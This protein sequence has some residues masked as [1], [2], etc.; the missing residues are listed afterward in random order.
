MRKPLT[1][2]DFTPDDSM[3]FNHDLNRILV[4][5]FLGVEFSQK[6]ETSNPQLQDNLRLI[7]GKLKKGEIY[8]D[9]YSTQNIFLVEI[10]L[11]HIK[12]KQ[13]EIAV[14]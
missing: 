3:M 1:T 7:S 6:L 9:A 8:L 13:I 2:Q 10:H 4:N 11:R 12:Q 14:H 5:R